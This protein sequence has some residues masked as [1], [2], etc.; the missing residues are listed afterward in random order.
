[1]IDLHV[2]TI[3]S[4]GTLSPEQVARLAVERRLKAIAVTDHDTVAGIA[5]AREE[6]E[7]LGLEVVPG[8]EMS[9][10]SEK[11]ILHILGYFVRV[12]E[13]GLL[14]SL[15]SLSR[16]RRERIP[17]I[18]SKLER[19][20]VHIANEE[21]EHE[22]VGGV[23]GRPHVARIMLRKGYVRALQEAFELYLKKGASAY[24]EKAKL[25]P[26]EAI[27]T[28]LKAGGLPVLAHPYS[29]GEDDPQRLEAVV[30][31]LMD[32]GLTG[33]EA[34]YSRHTRK[35]TTVFLRLASRLGLVVTGGSDF[36]GANKPGIELG[37]IPETGPLSYSIL[38]GLKRARV[39]TPARPEPACPE[40]PTA[41]N[42]R[43]SY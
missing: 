14:M 35:Q 23:P 38:E 8:V 15:E 25:S 9:A 29:L 11:G 18:L 21:V 17:K 16:A 41:T 4:D 37:V 32:Y 19:R 33:I 12:D 5:P 27:E 31:G 34:Y 39:R 22:A 24:V 10:Q 28:I 36:H 1:M 6:G 30:R 26:Q 43:S 2:H 40:R 3:I 7:Q 13:P 42:S 20:H